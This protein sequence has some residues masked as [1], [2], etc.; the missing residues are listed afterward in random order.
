MLDSWLVRTTTPHGG[1]ALALCALLGSAAL[2]CSEDDE[3][4][5]SA[6]CVGESC[7]CEQSGACVCDVEE[8]SDVAEDCKATCVAACSLTCLDQAKCQVKGDV[9]VTV[10]CSDDS[11]CK[12][13]GGDDPIGDG[14][15][16]ICSERSDC[17]FKAGASSVA[18]CAGDAHCKL[19]LG[20]G[21]R[22][23]CRDSSDCD[24]ECEGDCDVECGADASCAVECGAI[25]AGSPAI[26]CDDGRFLC[27]DEC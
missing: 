14:S 27:G 12:V 23:R 11:H 22:V 15:S 16:I 26:E 3:G 17:N 1:I 4:S 5:T 6:V 25:D 21:S 8:E 9:P 20:R 10:D 2:G 13:E 7:G 18:T 24:I 19:N